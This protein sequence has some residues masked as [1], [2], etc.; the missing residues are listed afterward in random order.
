MKTFSRSDGHEGCLFSAVLLDATQTEMRL[1][2][3]NEDAKKLYPILEEEKVFF[4]SNCSVSRSRQQYKLKDM[5]FELKATRDTQVQECIRQDIQSLFQKVSITPETID[6]ISQKAATMDRFDTLDTIAVVHSIGEKR[7]IDTKNGLVDTREVLFVDQTKH[8][9]KLSLWRDKATVPPFKQG[10]VCIL[11]N[12]GVRVYREQPALT[13]L[14]SS[15]L[16]VNPEWSDEA[17]KLAGWARTNL[18]PDFTPEGA[19]IM[20]SG[21]SP[22]ASKELRH[23]VPCREIIHRKCGLEFPMTFFVHGIVC[24][25]SSKKLYYLSCSKCKK[26]IEVQGQQSFCP[27]CQQTVAAVPRF[28]PRVTIMDES[29][30]LSAMAFDET[31]RKIIGHTAAEI[32]D[33]DQRNPDR[34]GGDV[35]AET[36]EMLNEAVHR[37]GI[38]KVT[39]KGNEYQGQVRQRC[40]FSNFIPL[41]AGKW[42][43]EGRLLLKSI[44]DIL[45]ME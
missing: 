15:Q 6:I 10:D 19:S 43:G 45:G 14:S 5:E 12:V 24:D 16:I 7:E 3:F 27:N 29:G 28:M 41:T 38:F 44:K 37:E 23:R 30:T 40:S 34:E 22:A 1:T 17:I 2:A 25:A 39:C 11:K 13:L 9:I 21:D 35:S 33:A 18:T 31:A 42:A 4:L 20:S 36:R 26:K 8:A 32:F